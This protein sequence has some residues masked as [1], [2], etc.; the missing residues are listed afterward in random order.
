MIPLAF[1]NFPK[2]VLILYYFRSTSLRY[3][4]VMHSIKPLYLF[5]KRLINLLVKPMNLRPEIHFH[6]FLFFILVPGLPKVE[7][8]IIRHFPIQKNVS[9]A[10][11]HHQGPSCT[12]V[13]SQVTS[14]VTFKGKYRKFFIYKICTHT[15]ILVNL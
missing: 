8:W 9:Q 2:F 3:V 14:F 6:T 4:V 5:F 11:S 15:H 12:S 7:S 10:Y 13:L 1:D